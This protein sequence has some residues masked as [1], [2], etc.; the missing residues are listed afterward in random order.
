MMSNVALIIVLLTALYLIGVA[1][2]SFIAPARARQF[3]DAFASSA[4]AHYTEMLIRLIVGAGLILAAPRLL[5]SE[6][7]NVFG[8][9]IVIT[10]AGLLL[11]PWQWHH[12]F[13]EKA[14]RPLTKRVWLFGVFSLPL[15]V[16][17]MY[18]V[19][20]GSPG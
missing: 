6:A 5:F 17:L 1:V 10:T 18:A 12:R 2:V 15:G 19:V 13:A 20:R 11:I 7:F 16:F 9:I 3:L 8:W 4:R 14:V